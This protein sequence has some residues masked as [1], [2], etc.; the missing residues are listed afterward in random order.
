M[1]GTFQGNDEKG[2]QQFKWGLKQNLVSKQATQDQGLCLWVRITLSHPESVRRALRP[3]TVSIYCKRMTRHLPRHV[4]QF[5]KSLPWLPPGKVG[6]HGRRPSIYY[7]R[8]SGRPLN[9]Y[10][11]CCLRLV[12]KQRLSAVCSLYWDLHLAGLCQL[13]LPLRPSQFRSEGDG[14]RKR[15][16]Y[17]LQS[18]VTVRRSNHG[19]EALLIMQTQSLPGHNQYSA[20]GFSAGKRR[21]RQLA[22]QGGYPVPW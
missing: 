22:K 1:Q 16:S 20:F 15:K 4:R 8:E 10:R 9:G 12:L 18:E 5:A 3:W 21:T 11:G 7:C 13:T 17:V 2:E 14:M 19:Y 6:K